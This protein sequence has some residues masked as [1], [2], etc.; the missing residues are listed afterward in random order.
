LYK[1]LEAQEAALKWDDSP[2]AIEI[3]TEGG[4]SDSAI[5]QPRI[6]DP[7]NKSDSSRPHFQNL[8]C[9][10]Y[11]A[12]IS[13]VHLA[14]SSRSSSHRMIVEEENNEEADPYDPWTPPIYTGHEHDFDTPTVDA[15][16]AETPVIDSPIISEPVDRNNKK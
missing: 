10:D 9:H 3:K 4:G 2:C 1:D 14:S 16:V 5:P 13:F 15:P 11:D 8:Y 7:G 6:Q 12:G